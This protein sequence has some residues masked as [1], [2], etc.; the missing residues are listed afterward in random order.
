MPAARPADKAAQSAPAPAPVVAADGAAAKPV[1]P[2]PAP[3]AQDLAAIMSASAER[4]R[5]AV[6]QAMAPSL[7]RQRESIRS[8]TPVA[9]EQGMASSP[10]F[11]IPW[12]KPAPMPPA[13][14]A[15]CDPLPA[16]QVEALIDE[17]ARRESLEPGLLR[18]V[19]RKESGFR[20]CAVS[21]S[22]ALGLM[23]LMPATAGQYHVTDAF[24]PK[25]NTAAG[26]RFLKS[27]LT[28]YGGDTGL[29]LGAYNAGPGRVDDAG[30]VPAF[31]ETTDYVASI[32][33]SV[34]L[35]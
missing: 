21:R 18:E 28:R 35:P 2:E 23:Q 31:P 5:A 4:Q 25:Q 9:V 10:F 20:P 6:Q 29:A 7:E 17:N 3:R 14:T 19:M 22:G 26:A 11:T 15:A 24:D 1:P 30:G 8:Q 32:L 16:A 34:I 33:S 13:L 27:L 12:P